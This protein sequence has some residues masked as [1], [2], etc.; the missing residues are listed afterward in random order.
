MLES[1]R[2]VV[3]QCLSFKDGAYLLEG[4]KTSVVP[5]VSLEFKVYSFDVETSGDQGVFS[6]NEAYLLE[7]SKPFV[8]KRVPIKDFKRLVFTVAK[9]DSRPVPKKELWTE[10]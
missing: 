6:K 9:S 4:C 1:F 3:S 10:A 7:D 8:R 5:G 2:A